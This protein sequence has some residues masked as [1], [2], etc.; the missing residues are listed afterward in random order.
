[1][2]GIRHRLSTIWGEFLNETSLHGC[3][4]TFAKQHGPLK[5]TLWFLCFGVMVGILVYTTVTFYLKY[6][7]FNFVT[8]TSMR[9]HPEIEFPAV[10]ICNLCRFYKLKNPDIDNFNKLDPLLMEYFNFLRSIGN[11]SASFNPF[12]SKWQKL[13]LSSTDVNQLGLSIQEVVAFGDVKNQPLTN[14]ESNFS[15]T[16]RGPYEKCFTF[17][18]RYSNQTHDEKPLMFQSAHELVLSLDTIQD[19]CYTN[20]LSRGFRLLLHHPDE[21]F[22]AHSP[23]TELASGH[24]HRMQVSKKEYQ[25][26]GSPYNSYQNQHCVQDSKRPKGSNEDP[27]PY[28]HASCVIECLTNRTQSLCGCVAEY[29]LHHNSSIF[30]TVTDRYSC[31]RDVWRS[32]FILKNTEV[33]DCKRPCSEIKYDYELSSMPAKKDKTFDNKIYLRISFKDMMV[34]TIKHE[35]EMDFGD[36]VSHLGGYMGFCLGASVLTL[37]ELV[38]VV[39][40]SLK[41]V[42]VHGH[43][44]EKSPESTAPTSVEHLETDSTGI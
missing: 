42:S 17:N 33:C 7:E 26:L 8:K 40:K 11:A 19:R 13:R 43:S 28:S 30:C 14:L 12:D 32:Y 38:E 18:W 37:L 4:N 31:S 2:A 21:P 9:Y 27:F 25:Y 5:R 39:L 15:I 10:T 20:M 34:T 44:L 36:I 3:K 29:L 35:K 41:A 23:S 24:F 22:H 16:Y 1:M 6:K